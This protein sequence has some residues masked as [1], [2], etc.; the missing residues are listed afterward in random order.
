VSHI[1]DSPEQESKPSQLQSRQEI[2]RELVEFVKL[3]CW[4]LVVFFAVKTYVIEGYEVQGPSMLPTL[5][6]GERILVFKL[7]QTL[8]QFGLFSWIEAV[9]QG[10]VIVF[11]S[12][13][14]PAKRYV[15]RVVAKGPKKAA[16]K[17][18]AAVSSA[19]E[20]VLVRVEGDVVY[21]NNRR[22]V[23]DYA[24]MEEGE[25]PQSPRE[26]LVGPGEYYVLGDNRGPS[27]DSRDF[28]S[29]ADDRVVGTAIVRFSPLHKFCLLP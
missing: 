17:A 8:S 14:E 1:P 4:F 18:V 22:L 10:D 26:V 27:R 3:I 15:K 29:V 6:Q 7:P 21:V 25:L 19:C 2:K 23:E 11:Q 20:G 13:D 9:R 5:G 28:G 12:P 16:D 24:R